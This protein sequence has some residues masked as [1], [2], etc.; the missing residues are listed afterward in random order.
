MASYKVRYLICIFIS[1]IRNRQISLYVSA[2]LEDFVSFTYQ[3]TLLYGNRPQVKVVATRRILPH[4]LI[5]YLVGMTVD[6]PEADNSDDDEGHPWDNSI[7]TCS[8]RKGNL[9]FL[10]P[11]RFVNHDCT[12][13]V[14]VLTHD[15]S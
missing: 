3:S 11:A 7:L 14:Q 2:S 1:L 12:P 5:D 4:K 10:G 6:I 15:L 8:R 13:N 9:A